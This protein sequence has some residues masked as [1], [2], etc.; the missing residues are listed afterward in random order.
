MPM[1][2]KMPEYNCEDFADEWRIFNAT[3]IEI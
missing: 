3:G 2:Y 1:C